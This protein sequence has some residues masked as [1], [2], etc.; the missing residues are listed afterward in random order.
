MDETL[1]QFGEMIAGALA[2]AVTQQGGSILRPL[3]MDFPDDKVARALDDQY[4]FGPA[5]LVNP[6]T[7]Y[8]ARSRPVYLPRTPGGWYDF[9]TGRSVAA[10]GG[11]A[12]SGNG[13]MIDVRAPFDEIPLLVRAGAIVP[14]G[15]ELQYAGEKPADPL[16]LLVY[17]G[18]DGAFTIYDDDGASNDYESGAFSRIPLRWTEAARTL[19]IGKREGTFPGM[20]ARRT[21]NIVVVTGARPVPFSFSLPPGKTVA[22]A[23]EAVTVALP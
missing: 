12:G 7:S 22:Y 5:F 10:P 17:S 2:G 23:G 1:G 15:P 18:A 21:F 14:F 9:W 6:V 11:S 16:T 20:L 8:K 19:T 3:V 13:G 4:M